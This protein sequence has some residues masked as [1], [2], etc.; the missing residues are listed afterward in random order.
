MSGSQI[1]QCSR[2]SSHWIF[3]NGLGVEERKKEK[4]V[5]FKKKKF[6]TACIL[7]DFDFAEGSNLENAQL[8]IH[9]MPKQNGT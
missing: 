5:F 8:I 6:N 1:K 4:P 9:F 7:T 3:V 2:F